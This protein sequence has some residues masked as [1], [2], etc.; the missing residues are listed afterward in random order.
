MGWRGAEE[1]FL[2]G[3]L[4]RG[5]L[6]TKGSPQSALHGLNQ[7]HLFQGHSVAG[8]SPTQKLSHPLPQ[9]SEPSTKREAKAGRG[10]S[11]QGR[12]GSRPPRG[13]VRK[14]YFI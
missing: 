9:G 2:L 11:G 3:A 1:G 12:P 13:D 6:R 10:D 4:G 7:A 14:M 8:Q 5:S